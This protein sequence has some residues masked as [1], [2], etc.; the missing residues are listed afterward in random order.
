MTTP[1]PAAAD[2]F[3]NARLFAL[4]LGHLLGDPLLGLWLDERAIE[5]FA[6]REL[7]TLDPYAAQ[8]AQA[9]AAWCQLLHRQA[10]DEGR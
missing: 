5:A 10:R 4:Q 1:N 8:I 3:R 7:A 6:A 2:H 9:E